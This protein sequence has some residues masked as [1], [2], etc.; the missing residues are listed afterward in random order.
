MVSFSPNKICD[1]LAFEGRKSTGLSFGVFSST[2]EGWVS[3]LAAQGFT[4]EI[5]VSIGTRHICLDLP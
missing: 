1:K 2:C 5:Y 3:A 4:F